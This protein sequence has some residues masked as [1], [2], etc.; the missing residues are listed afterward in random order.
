MIE[1]TTTVANPTTTD[2]KQT[3]PASTGD[4][5]TVVEKRLRESCYFVLRSVACEYHE[6]V[7]ILRGRAPSF[8]LKQIAQTL[9][10]KV[11]G[12]EIVINRLVVDY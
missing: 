11:D 5:Q 6:G 4:I 8:Y 10:G 2:I 12:V 9:A 7:L 1:K 3:L